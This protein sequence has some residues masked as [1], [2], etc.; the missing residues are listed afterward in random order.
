MLFV[1]KSADAHRTGLPWK[2]S[3]TDG[4]QYFT[5]GI[6]IITLSRIASSWKRYQ[7]KLI[8]FATFEAEIEELDEESDK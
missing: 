8:D 2:N 5:S 6:S 4:V 7:E 3:D 1:H